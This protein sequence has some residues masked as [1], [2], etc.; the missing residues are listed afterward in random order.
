MRCEFSERL[1]EQLRQMG[2][3]LRYRVLACPREPSTAAAATWSKT[4]E[5]RKRGRHR[6]IGM[7][8]GIACEDL[9]FLCFNF[10]LII[11]KT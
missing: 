10:L 2:G 1:A 11:R 8:I 4:R 6:K 7:Q 9:K 5:Q 3:G